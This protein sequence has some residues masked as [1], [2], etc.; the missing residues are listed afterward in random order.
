MVRNVL[1]MDS[2]APAPTIMINNVGSGNTIKL[3]LRAPA[4]II[5]INNAG[6]GNTIKLDLCAPVSV[7][8]S[9]DRSTRDTAACI[10]SPTGDAAA[11]CRPSTLAE[12]A[13]ASV[14]SR[15][16]NAGP[17]HANQPIDSS[18][19]DSSSALSL[20]RSGDSAGPAVPAQPVPRVFPEPSAQ[21]SSHDVS[22]SIEPPKMDSS[23]AAP[24]TASS[25]S[26]ASPM[27]ILGLECSLDTFNRW[28]IQCE[29]KFERFPTWYPDDEEKI[30]YG[31][32]FAFKRVTTLWTIHRILLR[33][34][35]PTWI[36]FTTFMRDLHVV[37][38]V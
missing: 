5:M 34:I 31:L 8:A 35:K 24:N 26:E 3:D 23:P 32:N 16:R 1:A 4:P 17:S 22:S 13:V 9:V 18:S 21:P 10:E 38:P 30:E 20:G 19:S 2:G 36:E 14:A 11:S 12:E 37:G 28:R 33:L 25:S 15:I 27:E 6:T 29:S 7:P